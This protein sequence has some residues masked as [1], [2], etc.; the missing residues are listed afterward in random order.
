MGSHCAIRRGHHSGI[1]VDYFKFKSTQRQYYSYLL[2]KS[3]LIFTSF[4][5]YYRSP[6]HG[7][8]H[9]VGTYT[10]HGSG[11]LHIWNIVIS[12]NITITNRNCTP[13]KKDKRPLSY[14]IMHPSAFSRINI[15]SN[16]F[17]LSHFLF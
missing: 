6:C 14:Q 16:S 11:F 9:G 15:Q 5:P 3:A 1:V 4:K 2:S 8:S 10:S 12:I 17:S 7:P 13:Q